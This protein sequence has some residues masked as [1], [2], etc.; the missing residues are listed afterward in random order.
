MKIS[1]I[2][3][4]IAGIILSISAS[5]FSQAG[6]GERFPVD[7]DRTSFVGGWLI[8]DRILLKGEY[9]RQN[10]N[11]FPDAFKNTSTSTAGYQDSSIL[12]GDKFSGFV[13]QGSIAF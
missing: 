7:I 5:T 9:V 10:Y 6:Q 4:M 1:I 2:K 13:I 3:I 12:A 11:G 8:S